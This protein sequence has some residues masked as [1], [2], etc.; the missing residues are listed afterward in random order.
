MPWYRSDTR[1]TQ[2][3]GRPP[4]LHPCKGDATKLPAQ[5]FPLEGSEAR[6]PRTARLVAEAAGYRREGEKVQ[7][8]LGG[9][10]K[11]G[12]RRRVREE[13]EHCWGGGWEEETP[14]E[15]RRR[16]VRERHRK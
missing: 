7:T 6:S 8:G 9:R 5:V 15:D 12:E 13:G 11:S 14:E 10:E 16:T 1:G 3:P 4:R 2:L